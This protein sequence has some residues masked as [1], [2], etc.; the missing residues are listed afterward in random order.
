M[1]DYLT[2]E[3]VYNYFNNVRMQNKVIIQENDEQKSKLDLEILI[4][5]FES[6]NY[7]QKDDLL[8][9]LGLYIIGYTNKNQEYLK[10]MESFVEFGD[11][12]II[13]QGKKDVNTE[14][15][16]IIINSISLK[17][18]KFRALEKYDDNDLKDFLFK[19]CIDYDQSWHLLVAYILYQEI[20]GEE[21]FD[22]KVGKIKSSQF[23]KRKFIYYKQYC[24]C[25]ELMIWMAIAAN[26]SS[27]AILD[28][29]NYAAMHNH[30]KTKKEICAYIENKYIP[31][32]EMVNNIKRTK[33]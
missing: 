24:Q 18:N 4:K 8:R 20:N 22:K 17:R 11:Y 5:N 10:L 6:K 28:S 14:F 29:I 21:K 27:K 15:I 3:E 30:E 19:K 12:K 7:L 25:V 13:K 9:M 26:L 1:I 31:W 2:Y 16:N 23:E 33:L 32:K